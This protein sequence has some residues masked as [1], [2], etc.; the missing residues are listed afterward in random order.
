[1]GRPLQPCWLV[2]DVMIPSKYRLWMIPYYDND[3]GPM[4]AFVQGILVASRHPRL[5]S[6]IHDHVK[7]KP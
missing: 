2:L 5:G 7:Q 4:Y 6:I 1:L 3:I